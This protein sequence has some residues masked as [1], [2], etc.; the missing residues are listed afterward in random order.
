MTDVDS[1]EWRH[2]DGAR[3]PVALLEVM[4]LS[5]PLEKAIPRR[6]K[7][8]QAL[9]VLSRRSGV[10]L[11]LVRADFSQ[12]RFEVRSWPDL[13]VV[14]HGNGQDLADWLA[15][16]PVLDPVEPGVPPRARCSVGRRK[17]EVRME[18][19]KALAF[20]RLTAQGFAPVDRL[21]RKGRLAGFGES[22][23]REAARELG[24]V[25]DRDHLVLTRTPP[26]TDHGATAQD[27]VAW[28]PFVSRQTAE[29]LLQLMRA[30]GV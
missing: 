20:L 8:L 3:V 10:P 2:K 16:L 19:T 4:P 6:R 14:L 28:F 12:D 1:V 17:E 15:N 21:L 26:L 25:E 11:Y 23:L 13:R 18:H 29:D 5:V 27:L 30:G 22:E 7:G 24:Y 9:E